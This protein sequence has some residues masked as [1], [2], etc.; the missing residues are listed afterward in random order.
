M[1]YVEIAST[2]LILGVVIISWIFLVISSYSLMG[3]KSVSVKKYKLKDPPL[4]TSHTVTTQIKP[5][6]KKRKDKK[7]SK[8]K[9]G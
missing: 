4:F 1:E 6:L 3:T 9:N 2:S 8:R 7:S 5:K